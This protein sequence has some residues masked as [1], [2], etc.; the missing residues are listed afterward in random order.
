MD[1]LEVQRLILCA[2]NAEGVSFTP[3]Q[4]TRSHM[5]QLK[6]SQVAMMI[7][8]PCTVMKI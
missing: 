1:F 4:G 7:E 3:D 8:G 5:P 6:I 2:S